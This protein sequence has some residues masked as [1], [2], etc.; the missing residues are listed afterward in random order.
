MRDAAVREQV[1]D[2]PDEADDEIEVRR[3]AGEEPG[4]D[5]PRDRARR[6]LGR[7]GR[8]RHQRARQR[9]RQY[10]IGKSENRGQTPILLYAARFLRCASFTCICA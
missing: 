1:F 7:R 3:R 8:A 4:R 10:P 6:H 5:P 9:V 2:R